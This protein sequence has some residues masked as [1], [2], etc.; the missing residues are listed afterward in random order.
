MQGLAHVLTQPAR[1]KLMAS[2]IPSGSPLPFNCLGRRRTPTGIKVSVLKGISFAK[3]DFR[4]EVWS[5][6]VAGADDIEVEEGED[7]E[8]SSTDCPSC[9]CLK[10]LANGQYLTSEIS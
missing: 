3:G 2:A 8:E 5:I 6:G 7:E 9:E 4:T 1:S 10:K